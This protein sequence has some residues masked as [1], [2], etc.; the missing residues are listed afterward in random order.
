MK[1]IATII[2]VGQKAWVSD[3]EMVLLFGKAVPQDLVNVSVIQEFTNDS[4][5]SSFVLQKGDTVTVAGQ[6]YKAT[7]VGE[8]VRRNMK[9]LGHLTLIFTVKMPSKPLADAVYLDCVG[10][11]PRPAFNLGDVIS[12][13]HI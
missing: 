5:L 11:Q 4:L 2:K 3:Q 6:T 1:W 12:Y 9:Y 7:F 8:M 10:G 13:E